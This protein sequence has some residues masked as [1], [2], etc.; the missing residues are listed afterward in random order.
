MQ[1][2]DIRESEK[3]RLYKMPLRKILEKIK[4]TIVNLQRNFKTSREVSF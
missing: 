4:R 1:I 2:L 3:L